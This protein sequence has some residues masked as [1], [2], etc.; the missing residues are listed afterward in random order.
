MQ[1]NCLAEMA[2][3]Y[4]SG[5]MVAAMHV[6]PDRTASYG[7]FRPIGLPKNRCLPVSGMVEKPVPGTAPSNIAAVG[8]YILTPMIFAILARTPKGAGGELQ[9][10][11]A[12]TIA[13]HAVPLVAFDFSGVRYDCGNHDGLLEASLARQTL[14]KNDRVSGRDQALTASLVADAATLIHFGRQNGAQGNNVAA[15]AG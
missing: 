1:E 13:T 15:R 3:H 12:I 6:K 2:A 4:H 10:T 9:L 5:H 8:R 11:D 7:V 14:V